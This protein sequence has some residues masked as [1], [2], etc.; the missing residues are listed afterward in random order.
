MIHRF[1]YSGDFQEGPNIPE[2]A[3]FWMPTEEEIP[4]DEGI[5]LFRDVWMILGVSKSNS[6]YVVEEERKSISLIDRLA[7]DQAEYEDIA[8]C[9][10]DGYIREDVTPEVR[11][12]LLEAVPEMPQDADFD[13]IY[14]DLGGLEVGVAGLAFALSYIGAVPVA[15][16]R[17]HIAPHT[18]SDRPVVLSAIDRQRADWL[19]P[20]LR[21]TGCGFSIDANRG[22]FLTVD[23]PSIAHSNGLAQAIL[24]E[25]SGVDLFDSWLDLSQVYRV[26]G[27]TYADN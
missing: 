18:W 20:L 27:S 19:L 22:E 4:E 13:V 11:A 21:Q 25:F 16:C 8:A 3:T 5:G 14:P 6:Q 26:D 17:A 10:D 12:R 9:F 15:S 2:H 1:E 24:A 23:A 7:T